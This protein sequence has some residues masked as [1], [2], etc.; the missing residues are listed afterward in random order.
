MLLMGVVLLL[1]VVYC[2]M[3]VDYDSDDGVV[4]GVV[5]AAMLMLMLVCVVSIVV[6]VDLDTVSCACVIVGVDD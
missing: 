4:N 6:G 3:V 5:D 1:V 2:V